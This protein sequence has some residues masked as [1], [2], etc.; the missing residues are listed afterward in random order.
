MP[1]LSIQPRVLFGRSRELASMR[2]KVPNRLM[3]GSKQ[4]LVALGFGLLSSSSGVLLAEETLGLPY[5]V[6]KANPAED[7]WHQQDV[8]IAAEMVKTAEEDFVEIAADPIIELVMT[9]VPPDSYESS[10]PRGTDVY[11]AMD[12]HRFDEDFVEIAAEPSTKLVMKEVAPDSYGS[13]YRSGID[14]YKA[15][16]EHSFDDE[17]MWVV[18]AKADPAMTLP[19]VVVIPVSMDRL[20]THITAAA[21]IIDPIARG[22]DKVYL[23]INELPENP[24]SSDQRKPRPR[25]FFSESSN[26]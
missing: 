14:V 1:S 20:Y 23:R 26:L 2:V 22:E 3:R 18:Y 24:A 11:K 10:Y 12:E 15:M 25:R 21:E 13:S 7:K 8:E 4:L 16:A 19:E 5:T 9:E 6:V 17:P